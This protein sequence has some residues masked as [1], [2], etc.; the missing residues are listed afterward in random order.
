MTLLFNAVIAARGNPEVGLPLVDRLIKERNYNDA[1]LELAR[2]MTDN[3]DDFYGGQ[4]RVRKIVAMREKYNDQALLLLGVIA[5]EPTNDEKKLKMITYLETLEK[6]PNESAQSFI[7]DTKEAAQFTYYRAKFDEIMNEGNRL[8]DEGLYTQAAFKF[9]EGYTFYKSDFDDEASPELLSAVN[10][11]LGRVLGLLEEYRTLE[12]AVNTSADQ[13]NRM[14]AN[15]SFAELDVALGAFRNDLVRLSARRNEIA[16]TGWFFTDTF[17]KSQSKNQVITD[18]SFL[19]FAWR[20]T[21]GRDTSERFEGV[22]GALDAQWNRRLDSFET[23]VEDAARDS[24]KKAYDA[25]GSGVVETS[26]IEISKASRILNEGRRFT[27]VAENFVLREQTYGQRDA[28]TVVTRYSRIQ[29]HLDALLALGGVRKNYNAIQERISNYSEKELSLQE[30][31]LRSDGGSTGYAGFLND[32][33]GV[34]NDINR[35]STPVE[36]TPAVSGYTNDYMRRKDEILAMIAGDRL[37]LHRNFAQQRSEAIALMS[38]QWQEM[39]TG[40][41]VKLE[42][43]PSPDGMS[44]YFYP[45]EALDDLNKVKTGA[46]NDRTVIAQLL[47]EMNT[48]PADV[49]QDS[50]YVE[51]VNTIRE[52]QTALSSISS[53]TTEDISRANAMVLQASLARQEAELRLAQTRAAL[54]RN[55]FQSARDNLQRSRERFS[56]SLALQDSIAL[57]QE[58]DRNLENLGNDIT[59][60]ENEYVVREVRQLISSGRNLYYLGNFD[61]AEQVFIQA[62]NRWR[63]TNIEQ[64]AEVTHWLDI[65]NTALSMKTGRNIPVS[66]PLYPQM[67]QILSNANKMYIQGRQLISTGGRMEAVSLLTDAKKKLQQV[68]L[69]YPLNREAGELTLR[70]DQVIDPEVFRLFFRQKVEYIRANYRSEGRTVYSELLDLYE[71]DPS[72]PGLKKLVDDVEIY[73]GVKIPPPNPASISRSTEL[74]RSARRIYDANTRSMF[75]V[76][77]SQLDEAI[78][79]NP[80]NQSAIALK[81]RVQTAIG[82]QAVAVLSAEDESRYQ[83][84]VQE[85]QRGNKITASAIVEQLLQNSKSRN[86]TKIL[87]LKKRIDSLL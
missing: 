52:T 39:Y 19:P 72:F 3:P 27:N 82:G 75:Q 59:R 85:L 22:L 14:V 74:T 16:E 33:A 7:R 63:V 84:A 24:W 32:L 9:T 35:V 57:R 31:R 43:V 37:A 54:K 2:Y 30:V 11:R 49:L 18:N 83:Q 61:Q 73:L 45:K 38:E 4:R 81:D 58:S 23:A 15:K 76:A 79:L 5:N 66:A 55:D 51:S 71:I 77:L 56:Q 21:L 26:E 6:N 80:D 8:I 29:I 47:L 86:S 40:S 25:V 42:G 13:A 67:S 36:N 34:V 68:Q 20:F 60:T 69:V 65:V 10:S 41:L 53:Q 48:A 1:I 64:N 44:T 87:D 46:E 50:A 28:T 78:K 17:A 70:I 12:L 62:N